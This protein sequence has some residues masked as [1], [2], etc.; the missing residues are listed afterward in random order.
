METADYALLLGSRPCWSGP[1][2]RAAAKLYREGRVKYVVPSGGVEW[3][4]DGEMLSEALYMKRILMEEGVPEE[5]I[6]LENE[7]TTTRENLIYGT[8]QIN[9]KTKFYG[10][11]KV[12]IVSSVNHMRRSLALAKSFLPSFVEIT[13]SPSQPDESY[14]ECMENAAILDRAIHLTWGLVDKGI[15]EDFEFDME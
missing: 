10:M 3:D 11:K 5:A 13:Y 1:R 15:I 4:T 9:R 14:E 2:A 12:M 6:I 7:A 8:L